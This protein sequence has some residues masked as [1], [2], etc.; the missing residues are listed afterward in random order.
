[1]KYFNSLSFC[2]VWVAFVIATVKHSA[3]CRFYDLFSLAAS[4]QDWL[5]KTSFCTGSACCSSC[6]MYAWWVATRSCCFMFCCRVLPG[7]FWLLGWL[8]IFYNYCHWFQIVQGIPRSPDRLTL[9]AADEFVLLLLAL[10]IL[11]LLISLCFSSFKGEAFS[12]HVSRQGAAGGFTASITVTN[13]TLIL[14][15]FTM[16][17]P[18]SIV[19]LHPRNQAS[20]PHFKKTHFS[21]ST[22]FSATAFPILRVTY[23]LP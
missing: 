11:S 22:V 23:I 1:M 14:T 16:I 21:E 2:V 15:I 19:H 8:M 17:T 10:I 9:A 20:R 4:R 12:D 3:S 18:L 6:S 13:Y 5:Q 7:N